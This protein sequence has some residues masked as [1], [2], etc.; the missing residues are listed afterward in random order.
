[1]G[2]YDRDYFQEPQRGIQIGGD[3]TMVTNLILINVASICR[4]IHTGKAG[5]GHLRQPPRHLL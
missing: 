1:M 2:I 3:R 4:R 5:A